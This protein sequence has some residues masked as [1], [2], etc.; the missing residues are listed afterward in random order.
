M[1]DLTMNEIE[2]VGGGDVASPSEVGAG[3]L[4]GGTM[5]LLGGVARGAAAGAA[6]G[7]LGGV[8]GAVFGAAIGAAFVVISASFGGGGHGG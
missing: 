7:A 2:A 8:G 1:R 4:R 5:G 6:R 3:A